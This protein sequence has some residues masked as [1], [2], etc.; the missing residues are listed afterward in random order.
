MFNDKI[1]SINLT[2]FEAKPE[3]KK[4]GNFKKLFAAKSNIL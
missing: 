4:K 1:H 3:S 2:H